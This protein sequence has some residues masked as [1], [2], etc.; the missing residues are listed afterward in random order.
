MEKQK[1]HEYLKKMY[2][3][4]PNSLL[5]DD[6]MYALECRTVNDYVEWESLHGEVVT[7]K[8]EDLENE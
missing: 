3:Q 4:D 6:S 7:Y 8:L 1:Y 2:E 5:A